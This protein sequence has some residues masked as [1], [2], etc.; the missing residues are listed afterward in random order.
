MDNSRFYAG[1]NLASTN[2]KKVKLHLYIS[3]RTQTF[4]N[5]TKFRL[6]CLVLGLVFRA[7]SVNPRVENNLNYLKSV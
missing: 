3:L 4:E 5:V 2:L 6:Q 1:K 7:R